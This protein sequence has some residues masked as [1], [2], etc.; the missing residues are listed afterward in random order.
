MKTFYIAANYPRREEIH[1][2]AKQL[3][4]LGWQNNASWVTGAQE[5]VKAGKEPDEI[6]DAMK[7][8]WAEQD[9]AEIDDSDTIIVCDDA[10]GINRGGFM[11]EFGYAYRD[12]M[13]CIVIGQRRNVFAYLPYVSWYETWETFL[14][15]VRTL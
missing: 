12:G 10:E 5:G 4:M 15:A 1:E 14:D 3:E 6:T 13:R 7:R 9:C 2:R 8:A 11:W